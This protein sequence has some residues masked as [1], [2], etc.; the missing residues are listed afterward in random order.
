MTLEQLAPYYR[1]VFF[2]TVALKSRFADSDAQGRK[3]STDV[4]TYQRLIREYADAA[5]KEIRELKRG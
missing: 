2:A 4:G 1:G 5:V 3:A